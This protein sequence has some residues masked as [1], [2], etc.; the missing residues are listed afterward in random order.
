MGYA[1]GMGG[2]MNEALNGFRQAVQRG[3]TAEVARLLTVPSI[4]AHVNDPMFD[5]GQRAT[6]VA[7]KNPQLLTVL[8]EAS[9]DL[10]LAS[11]WDKGP[12]TVLDQAD[13]PTARFLMSRGVPL[14]ANVA[15]RLGWLDELAA[16][17]DSAPSVVHARGG[18][19]KQP[20]HEARTPAIADFLLD[21]GAGI[22][23]R[24]I[25]HH[26]TPAQYALVD[27]P[28]VCQRLLD[29]GALPDIFMAAR[30]GDLALAERL[31]AE[32]D[33]CLTARVHAPGYAPVPPFAIYCWTLGF[34]VSP[35][36]VARR[37]GHHK[38][39][40]LFVARSPARVRLMNAVTVGDEAAAR[41]IL[42]GD[43]SLLSSLTAAEHG[44]LAVAIFHERFDAAAVMLRLGFDP[45]AP[46]PDGGTALHAA[47]WVGHRPTVDL[48]LAR[49]VVPI[50]ARD[51]THGSTPLGWA[52]FGSVHRRAAHGDYP[53]V[54]ERL[55]AAGADATAPG[56]R[57]GKT[58]LEMAEGNGRMQETLAR[59]AD[60]AGRGGS[61]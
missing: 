48:I 42:A 14:T 60:T 53:A 6:H 15:A 51:P 9:A 28:D 44:R 27:R 61:L 7:A 45:A 23:V 36:Q 50:D 4:R 3:D 10:T 52:A 21:R 46:G 54:A 59:L 37:F 2:T 8:I 55:V 49:G 58:L 47:C 16:L 26:S 1:D 22:D 40:D 43:A 20:L 30:L 17:V 41:A 56:N 32:D 57:L 18:D 25:D 35:E 24:C 38:V 39:Q 34:D 13:E 5:F 19:G 29:R 31:I 33:G 12:F 11:D